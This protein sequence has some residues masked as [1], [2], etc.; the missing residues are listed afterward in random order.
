M[1]KKVLRNTLLRQMLKKSIEKHP[2]APN[3]EKRS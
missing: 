3:V 1:L 2:V